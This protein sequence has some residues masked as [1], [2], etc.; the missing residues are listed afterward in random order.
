VEDEPAENPGNEQDDERDQ[1]PGQ[2]HCA[3][4]FSLPADEVS[5]RLGVRDGAECLS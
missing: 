3:L 4:L 2:E 5:R 1:E